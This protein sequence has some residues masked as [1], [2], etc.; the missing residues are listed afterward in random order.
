LGLLLQDYLAN[1]PK[2]LFCPGSDQ[3]LDADAELQKVGATQAQSGYYYR[4]AGVTQLF[5]TPPEPVPHLQLDN[6]GLNRQGQPIRALVMDT[7]FECPP[8]LSA[9][10]I[11]ST[12]HHRKK[13]ANV[14]YS[15]SHAAAQN[16]STNRYTVDATDYASLHQAFDKILK[17][18]E[19]ADPEP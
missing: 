19:A 15:D 11:A 4:H 10:G 8:S 9:F 13:I 17:A 2:V 6:L 18:F 7:Q 5:Y 1:T 14:L 12:T 3:S 16:N